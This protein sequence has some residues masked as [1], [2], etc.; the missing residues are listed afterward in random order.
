MEAICSSETL[1]D[2]H[3]ITWRYIPEDGTLVGNGVVRYARGLER[4][5]GKRFRF[6]VTTNASRLDDDAIK[7]FNDEMY[8]VVISIDGREQ[9]HNFVRRTA[10]GRGTFDGTLANALRFRA[11]RGDK[12]YYIRGTYT[13]RNKDF[14]NDALYLADRGF[15]RISLEPVVLDAPHPLALTGADSAELCAEYERLAG[16]YIKRRKNPATWFSF[17]HFNIDVENGPCETKRLKN[18]GAGCG[19]AA[20]TPDG[21]VY[22]CH[23]FAGKPGYKMGSVLDGTFDAAISKKFFDNTLLN[24]P[25]CRACWAKYYCGGGCA[26]NS[27]DFCGAIEEPYE[28]AC[29]LMKK[30]LECALAIYSIE[31]AGK[32]RT[33]NGFIAPETEINNSFAEK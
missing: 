16:E 11:A 1:V 22:P 6:T 4:S 18:C 2:S 26:A 31:R 7:F 24:K 25:K 8:N 14:A 5:A 21:A 29:A 15:D 19:Y 32:N 3:R 10:D 9:V 12:Q 23:R 33:K 13:N 17:F 20:V 30:R 27:A 28:A